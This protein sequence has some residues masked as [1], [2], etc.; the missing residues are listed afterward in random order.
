MF[1]FKLNY[2]LIT[3]IYSTDK[4]DDE[5]PVTINIRRVRKQIYTLGLGVK[6]SITFKNFCCL[7]FRG[8]RTDDNICCTDCIAAI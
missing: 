1:K 2:I 4:R 3:A 5:A 8:I 7:W 6:G